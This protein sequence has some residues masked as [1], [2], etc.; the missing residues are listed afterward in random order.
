MTFFSDPIK[1]KALIVYTPPSSVEGQAHAHLEKMHK[2]FMERSFKAQVADGRHFS[3]SWYG[4]ETRLVAT[5]LEKKIKPTIPEGAGASILVC[6]NGEK[7]RHLGLGRTSVKGGH[8]VDVNTAAVIGSGAKMLAGLAS[9]VL[10]NQGIL[11]LQTKLS[12]VME[13]RHFAIFQDPEAAKEITLDMLLS[14]TSGLQFHAEISRNEREGMTLDAILDA[15]CEEVSK[16]PKK[17]IQ[18]TGVPGDGIYAY[19]NQISLAAVFLEKA[20][21]RAYQAAHP[22]SSER[23]TY[24]DILRREVFEPLGMSRTSFVKP[25]ENVMRAY[26]DDDG[27]PQSEDADIRDPMHQP[28]GGLWST[29]ADM[30]KLAQAF[31][32]AFKSG[33]GLKSADGRKVLL[34]PE[35][36]EDFLRPRGVSGVTALGIDVVG[37]FFGKGGEISTYDFKFSFD[38]ETGSYIVSLCNFKNSQK[39]GGEVADGRKPGYINHVIP[40][41]DEMHARFAASK[42]PAL[43]VGAL[44]E[45]VEPLE[46]LPLHSCDLFFYGGMGIIGM[47]AKNSQWLNWNG[48]ILPIKQVGKNKFLITG[49]GLHAGKVVRFGKG[50]KG[51]SYVFIETIPKTEKV[52]TPIAFKAVLPGPWMVGSAES[53]RISEIETLKLQKSLPLGEIL[54]AQGTYISTKGAKGASPI[55]VIIDEETGDIKVKSEERTDAEGRPLEIPMTVSNSK[56]S[57]DGHLNELWLVGNFMRVPLYQLKLSKQESGEWMLEVVDFSSKDSVDKMLPEEN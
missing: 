18:L 22:E 35:S 38:R 17:K 15:M 20:Y 29:A 32:K 45:I 34:S 8:P 27:I 26:R 30:G 11:S 41:L 10:E 40:T 13:E 47:E 16:D 14:H 5:D 50:N 6:A 28:A 51:N 31:A 25:E 56:Q 53:N 7:P 54:D 39:F 55:T 24:A 3:D 9:K 52:I 19:S 1:S 21:H 57:I 23:F 49:E 43:V 37:S 48:E 2:L 36:L 44:Q 4:V 12:E 42:A 33:E 46:S